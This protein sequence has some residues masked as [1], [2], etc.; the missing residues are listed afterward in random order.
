MADYE[1]YERTVEVGLLLGIAEALREEFGICID[2]HPGG[3]GN[4]AGVV[5]RAFRA[6]AR[7]ILETIVPRDEELG[8]V[9]T[10]VLRTA[11]IK[12]LVEVCEVGQRA[13]ALIDMEPGLGDAWL[14]YL[15]LAPASLLVNLLQDGIVNG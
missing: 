4:E 14:T 9:L 3:P 7:R 11:A 5:N 1:A 15:A 2:A 13:E 10:W 6:A 8:A 12:R